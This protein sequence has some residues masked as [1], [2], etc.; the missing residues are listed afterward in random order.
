ML[1]FFNKEKKNN[2]VKIADEEFRYT[3]LQR[4]IQGV[5]CV[6]KINSKC[7]VTNSC[8]FM[9]NKCGYDRFRCLA[10]KEIFDEL[11]GNN[12]KELRDYIN[13]ELMWLESLGLFEVI[14]YY[15]EKLEKIKQKI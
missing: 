9:N 10:L 11:K 3:I 5:G 1:N 15:N 8:P 7:I 13:K 2:L 4:V 6:Y 14:K 12:N